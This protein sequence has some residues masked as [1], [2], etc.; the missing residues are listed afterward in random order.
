M[1]D[2]SQS[3]RKQYNNNEQKKTEEKKKNVR[4]HLYT[5]YGFTRRYNTNKQEYIKYAE[6]NKIIILCDENT[7][8]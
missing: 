5:C 6:A 8:K 2:T 1:Y 4:T 3:D 7:E